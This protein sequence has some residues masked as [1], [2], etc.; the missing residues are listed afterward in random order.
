VTVELYQ[1][2]DCCEVEAV[3]R[4][5]IGRIWFLKDFPFQRS[6]FFYFILF[7][8]IVLYLSTAGGPSSAI[9]S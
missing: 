4:K 7:A 9:Y 2:F 5:A 3:S 6:D 1:K 8:T